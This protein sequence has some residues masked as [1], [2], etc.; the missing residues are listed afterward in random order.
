LTEGAKSH[1]R[2]VGL[3][4]FLDYSL[5]T[6]HTR[7]L[8]IR[9]MD[10]YDEGSL[11]DD[12]N[13]LT[14]EYSFFLRVSPEKYVLVN[15]EAVHKVLGTS[16]ATDLADSVSGNKCAALQAMFTEVKA[17]GFD[18]EYN[19]RRY[20]YSRNEY[21]PKIKNRSRLIYSRNT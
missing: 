8:I 17:A 15:P 1:I 2:R 3:G 14:D 13:S 18:V 5:D 4:T 16:F 9:L 19:T 7:E 6:L 21:E 12:E 11:P 10:R 20:N